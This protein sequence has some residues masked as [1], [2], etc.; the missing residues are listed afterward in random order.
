TPGADHHGL[1]DVALLDLAV[2]QRLFDADHDH[3][4]EARIAA[5]RAAEHLDTLNDLGSR[6]VG[7]LEHGLH[8]DHGSTQLR[9]RPLDQAGH[10]PA[11]VFG[12]RAVLDD[13]HAITDP[14]FVLFVV[15]LVALPNSNVL[16]VHRVHLEAD[17][18]DADRL[19]HLV[20]VNATDQATARGLALRADLA[21]ALGS[22]SSHDALPS[23]PASAPV[24]S[25]RTCSMRAMSLRVFRSRLVSSSCPV[26]FFMRWEN[27]SFF[28]L[29]LSAT[30]SSVVRSLR[31]FAF[32]TYHLERETASPWGASR[33]P[34]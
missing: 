7:D 26:K 8:L 34:A 16:L 21:F 11:L 3:V 20:A 9:R 17:H 27:K 31:S 15:R 29:V 19:V 12:H 33:P 32:I 30:K 6:V 14:V 5:A 28:R 18:L 10:H 4:T 22:C 25:C 1:G 23:C 13:L 2:G 24:R